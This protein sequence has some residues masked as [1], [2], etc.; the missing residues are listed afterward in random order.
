[1]G[2]VCLRY[3]YLWLESTSCDIKVTANNA[4]SS[5]CNKSVLKS[6]D[7]FFIYTTK[8][9]QLQQICGHF[10][11]ILVINKPTSTCV[12]MAFDRL[13]TTSLLWVRGCL[14]E[15][16]LSFNPDW[17][18]SVSVE[19]TGDWI[20]FVYMNPDWVAT[21]SGSSSFHFFIPDWTLDAEWNVDSESCKLESKFHFS[22]Y[23]RNK[24]CLQNGKFHSCI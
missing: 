19:I 1:M 4:T 13:S 16:G 5:N 8:N 23:G 20:V 6:V 15:S 14:H 24:D 7:R 12:R 3:S 17:T 22:L 2:H 9:A 10:F 21:H 18:H 11:N